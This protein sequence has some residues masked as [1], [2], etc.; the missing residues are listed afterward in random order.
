VEDDYLE[1]KGI[2]EPD[3]EGSDSDD[4]EDD[5]MMA[6]DLDEYEGTATEESME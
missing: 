3:Q 4:L 2:P 5:D 1:W 6:D